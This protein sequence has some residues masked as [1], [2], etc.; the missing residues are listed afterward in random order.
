VA[1]PSY[2]LF[3]AAMI[4]INSAY[5]ARFQK[6]G[7]PSKQLHEAVRR[8]GKLQPYEHMIKKALHGKYK[9]AE[10]MKHDLLLALHHDRQPAPSQKVS[11][12]KKSAAGVPKPPPPQQASR[13]VRRRKK[14]GWAFE[15]VLLFTFFSILYL[16]YMIGQTM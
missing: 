12:V 5:P 16:F 8:S 4:M 9:I 15:T 14:K 13:Q 6:K 11:P 10:E 2:D 7:E 1:E 3:S